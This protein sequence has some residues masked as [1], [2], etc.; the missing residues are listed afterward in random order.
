MEFEQA[1]YTWGKNQLSRHREGL[2]ICASSRLDGEFLDRCLTLGSR[3]NSERTGETAEFVLYAKEFD[4][5]VGVGISPRADGG[6]G[7]VNKLCHFF[8]P[9]EAEEYPLPDSYLLEYPFRT[10]VEDGEEIPLWSAEGQKKC[11]YREIIEQYQ[12]KGNRLAGLLQMAWPC[13]FGEISGF[14]ILIG[15]EGREEDYDL[16][17]AREITWFLSIL[18]PGYGELELGCR[19]NL[20]YGVR[21]RENVTAVRIIYTTEPG[22]DGQEFALDWEPDTEELLPVFIRMAECAERSVEEYKAFTEGL[23]KMRKGARFRCS[24]LPVLF[25]RWKL[26]NGE[27][28]SKQEVGGEIDDILT[29]AVSSRWEKEFMEEYLLQ[30]EDL[31]EADIAVLW[32]RFV[33]PA[34]QSRGTDPEED[35]EDRLRKIV[36]KLLGSMQRLNSVN[37]VKML[38]RTP[39]SV[40]AYAAGVLYDA[41]DSPVRR[42]LDEVSSLGEMED[43]LSLYAALCRKGE[44]RDRLI[45]V[46]GKLYST[47]DRQER[48]RISDLMLADSSLKENWDRKMRAFIDQGD[49]AEA[50]LTFF[51]AEG[52]PESE[53][54]EFGSLIRKWNIR[55]INKKLRAADIFGLAETDPESLEYQ[56]CRKCWISCVVQKLRQG[57]GLSDDVYRK[58]LAWIRDI[59][60]WKEIREIGQPSFD[61]YMDALWDSSDR[62]MRARSLERKILFQSAGGDTG[63]FSVWNTVRMEEDFQDFQFIS[64][65]LE[66]N[67]QMSLAAFPKE[68]DSGSVRVKKAIYG[69]WNSA[70]RGKVISRQDLR[71]LNGQTCKNR[72]CEVGNIL[73]RIQKS[74]R[75][76]EK[77]SMTMTDFS[78][79]MSLQKKRE[80]IDQNAKKSQKERCRKYRK[81]DSQ[82]SPLIS[83]A[84]EKIRIQDGMDP[85]MEKRVREMQQFFLV[86]AEMLLEECKKIFGDQIDEIK[87]LEMSCENVREG[88]RKRQ[89]ELSARKKEILEKKDELSARM[90]ELEKERKALAARE[91][92][93]EEEQR[94]VCARIR[95]AEGKKTGNSAEKKTVQE[96]DDRVIR[97]ISGGGMKMPDTEKRAVSGGKGGMQ[98]R[99]RAWDPE[100]EKVH[101]PEQRRKMVR[102][103]SQVKKI[104]FNAVNLDDF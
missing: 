19:K 51:I 93:I 36:R 21:T 92:E 89:A 45:H 96:L 83:F 62:E 35:E 53:K 38:R 1:F 88:W 102:E 65:I 101:E 104:G 9:R 7:R 24:H 60:Y 86:I 95:A 23:L 42:Q 31:G 76:P 16:K 40:R 46:A 77:K 6:D 73:G 13:M 41:E 15:G 72:E 87:E 34:I 55:K 66:D 79:Y 32:V 54:E 17:A 99:D 2:G 50:F 91:E 43:F 64:Q 80:S 25:L 69:I 82:G 85:W 33:S 20:S 10:E 3:F 57:E 81:W 90:A 97:H 78:N 56:D 4:R 68:G 48:G 22:G 11:G 26:E 74:L 27:Y 71:I 100:P 61:E 47:A 29:A 63:T 28:V 98:K 8:I 5:F 67:P 30:A 39:A 94:A 59:S 44:V 12:L 49:D 58:L 52:V 103:E 75:S 84:A 18:A 37:Y 70:V 14:R